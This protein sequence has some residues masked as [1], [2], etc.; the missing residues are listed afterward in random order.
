MCS[1]QTHLSALSTD[2]WALH[3]NLG[4]PARQ[5]LTRDSNSHVGLP[6]WFL[7]LFLTKS[8]SNE[9]PFNFAL[10]LSKNIDFIYHFQVT[11][12]IVKVLTSWFH[13]LSAKGQGPFTAKLE[14][15]PPDT[16]SNGESM[17]IYH[18][19]ES[20]LGSVGTESNFG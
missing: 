9:F 3:Y 20:S 14:H 8:K 10:K 19:P 18:L 11:W 15:Q 4:V 17:N 6:N 2:K 1:I 7:L 5:N 16:S 12:R 13:F